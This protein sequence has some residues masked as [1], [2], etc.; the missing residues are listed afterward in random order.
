[1]NLENILKQVERNIIKIGKTIRE[2]REYYTGDA[3]NLIHEIKEDGTLFTVGDQVSNTFLKNYLQE[4]TPH[5]G[6]FG[7]ETL[8]GEIK[9]YTWICDPLDGT[10]AWINNESK[11]VISL[12]LREKNKIIGGVIYNPKTEECFVSYDGAAP[13]YN[14]RNLEQITTANMSE[15]TVNVHISAKKERERRIVTQLKEEGKIKVIVETGG[16]VAYRLAQVA[17]GE[18]HLF[19]NHHRKG[20]GIWDVAAGIHLVQSVGGKVTGGDGDLFEDSQQP[21][22]MIAAANSSLHSQLY[23][24]LREKAYFSK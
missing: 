14:G 11:Y 20:S 16:S 6:F 4:H 1:M 9:E 19:L 8:D 15:A 24:L 21:E 23:A 10:S 17:K 3:K 5:F 7:E 18:H 22:C 12:A 2:I 13:Q